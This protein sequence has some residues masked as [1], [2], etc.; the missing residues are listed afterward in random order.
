MRLPHVN[1]CKDVTLSPIGRPVQPVANVTGRG[2]SSVM[3]D[4]F[5]GE[6]DIWMPSSNRSALTITRRY[7]CPDPLGEPTNVRMVFS[8]GG[9]EVAS[10]PA[11]RLDGGNGNVY[12]ATFLEGEMQNGLEIA[13]VSDCGATTQS[14]PIGSLTLI[15]PSGR[16]TDSITG[17]PVVDA[18]VTLHRIPDWSPRETVAHNSVANT[19]ESPE[20]RPAGA[21][22]TQPVPVGGGV[23]AE[24]MDPYHVIEPAVNPMITNDDGRYARDVQGGSCWYVMV[25]K[26]G[27]E[28]LM[29]PVVGVFAL[30]VLDLHLRMTP[31]PQTNTTGDA[32]GTTTFPGTTVDRSREVTEVRKRQIRTRL[33]LKVSKARRSTVATGRLLP[34]TNANPCGRRAR[35]VILRRAA[36]G[37]KAGMS[38][39]AVA[40]TTTTQGGTFKVVL[41]SAKRGAYRAM[42]LGSSTSKSL[43][44]RCH[45]P[46]RRR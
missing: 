14:L 18:R 28:P 2:H 17:L 36:G 1:D 22:W 12:Q 37:G 33:L 9:V 41:P 35:I 23:P 44:V 5:T 40:R 16:I 4:P 19:C 25:E 39:A 43:C 3:V 32:T 21:D 8:S 30:P 15:D 10:R 24:P 38:W 11:T 20:T 31:L 29:S 26:A 46:V 42:Y 7:E 6:L 34:S 13:V 27:Y 45:S